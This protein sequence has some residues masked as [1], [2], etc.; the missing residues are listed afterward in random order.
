MSSQSKIRT[1]VQNEPI[2]ADYPWFVISSFVIR[3]FEEAAGRIG[4]QASIDIRRP[5]LAFD[6]YLHITKATTF[7]T[8]QLTCG[9][10]LKSTVESFFGA[11]QS[12][13]FI[14]LTPAF[15]YKYCNAF[16][17][18]LLEIAKILPVP[19]CQPPSTRALRHT[20][21]NSHL[22]DIR[23]SLSKTKATPFEQQCISKFN[24]IAHFDDYA[25]WLWRGWPST[26]LT[27]RTTW[28]KLY[29]ISQR[30]G[31]AFTERLYEQCDRFFS[32]RRAMVVPLI[33][34]LA[35]FIGQYPGV[36][37]ERDFQSPEFMT[38]FWPDFLVFYITTG[39]EE[40]LSLSF[41]ADS[42]RTQF[43]YFVEEFLVKNGVVATSYGR[44]PAPPPGRGPGYQTN[45]KR[46]K[47]GDEIHAKLLV[48]IPLEV[49]DEEAMRL[50]FGQLQEH[51]DLILKW[52]RESASD[53]WDRRNLR[54]ALASKGT[55]RALPTHD[56][57]NNG[58]HWITD[59]GN[60][61]R[62][63]NAC[64]T[65]EAYGHLTNSDTTIGLLYPIPLAETARGLGLP[66]TG[67][68]LPHCAILI[69]NHPAIT[70]AFLEQLELFDRTGQQIG[71]SRVDGGAVLRGVK[72][73]KG[74]HQGWQEIRLNAESEE[75]I[76]QI[77]EITAPLRNYLRERN[78]DNWRYLLLTCEHAF[79]HPKRVSRLASD[80][81]MPHRAENLAH[82]I[83][84]STKRPISECKELVLKFSLGSLRATAGVLIYLKTKD[85]NQMAEALGHTVYSKKLLSRYLPDAIL[86]FFQ[87]R[88]IR[89]FQTCIVLDAMKDSKFLLPAS[90]FKD[91][92]ELNS[93]LENHTL[94]KIPS[95]LSP[96]DSLTAKE[97]PSSEIQ[98]VLF[99]V[100][101][102]IL[103]ALVSLQLSIQKSS[104]II[105]ETAG[106]WYNISSQLTAFID[107][108]DCV[109]SD[110]KAYLKQA[111]SIADPDAMTDIIHA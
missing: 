31:R 65:Y 14:D 110:L 99:G 107:S 56:N 106:Y 68:L 64:A 71:F 85:V 60:P 61:M 35:R 81:S 39:D 4:A 20:P 23:L 24:E 55:V 6:C 79:G 66:T 32:N 9:H 36:L 52:A 38:R 80:T 78:D 77:I 2:Y 3:Q 11:L 75:I 57:I 111:R 89:I 54:L 76:R 88:W 19:I 109:R 95:S 50:L 48:H 102:S 10:T 18:V 8:A 49:K 25:I 43:T 45:I 44:L 15:R 108:D 59:S 62:F 13:E 87:E 90:G 63:P 42:W 105:N 86:S 1:I 101:I 69:V 16:H 100:D 103:V 29:P 21:S 96:P 30:V 26:N 94:K 17:K 84:L 40:G 5:L 33:T 70:S 22:L 51:V 91:I 41:M 34:Y 72:R 12:D 73:R 92:S 53:L 58:A 93:F 28:L 46:T 104:G 67:A 7:D 82:E 37:Q 98:E 97:Q 47:S 83:H 27:G 74:A